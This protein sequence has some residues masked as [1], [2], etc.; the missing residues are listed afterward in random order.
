MKAVVGWRERHMNAAAT[1]LQVHGQCL[2]LNS[3][4]FKA[5]WSLPEPTGLAPAPA[6]HK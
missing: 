2:S 1:P 3:S 4:E 5:L 6:R